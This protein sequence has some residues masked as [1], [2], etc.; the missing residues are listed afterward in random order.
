MDAHYDQVMDAREKAGQ[1]TKLYF[2]YSTILDRAAFEEWRSQHG[3]EFFDLPKGQQVKGVDLK[4]VYDFPSRWWGGR[5]AGL[6][7]A[8]GEAVWGLLFEIAEKDWPIVMHKEGAVT[9]MCVERKVCVETADG[10][11]VDALAFTTNP[12]RASADGPVSPRFV[13]ALKRGATSAGLPNDW[14]QKLG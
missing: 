2:A 12:V 5:V 1:G 7:D 9:G 8:P 13:E 3:Y 11:K 10:R 14:V 4:L 6:A